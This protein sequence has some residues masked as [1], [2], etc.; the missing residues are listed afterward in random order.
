M[1]SSL[2]SRNMSSSILNI[3]P[4]S[5]FTKSACTC[6]VFALSFFSNFFKESWTFFLCKESSSLSFSSRSCLQFL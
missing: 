1:I 4:S 5:R 3:L 2:I 6:S